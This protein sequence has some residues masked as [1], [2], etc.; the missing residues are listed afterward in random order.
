MHVCPALYAIIR[1]Y[2]ERKESFRYAT[3]S[4]SV[5][6]QHKDPLC[7]LLLECILSTRN[8]MYDAIMVHFEEGIEEIF[9]YA[10]TK[11]YIEHK[12][13]S[14]YAVIRV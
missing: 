8:N 13:S 14:M 4:I 11:V 2:T 7:M 3:C 12:K 10:A 5:Y 1:A 6:T 9:N